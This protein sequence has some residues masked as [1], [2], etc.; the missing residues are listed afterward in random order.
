MQTPEQVRE[1]ILSGLGSTDGFMDMMQLVSLL[2]IPKLREEQE[3]RK[4]DSKTD[5]DNDL[6]LY[7]VE[8]LL[9][10]VTGNR[11]PKPL[12]ETLIRQIFQAYGETALSENDEL[13]S[14]MMKQAGATN[15]ERVLLDAKTFCQALTSDLQDFNVENKDKLS[16]NFDDVMNTDKFHLTL[17]TETAPTVEARSDHTNK[18]GNTTTDSTVGI[19]GVEN[20]DK[21]AADF[22]VP[23]AYTAPHIDNTADTFRSRPLVIFQWTF[24]VASFQT[25]LIRVLNNEMLNIKCNSFEQRATWIKNV[26]AFFCTLGMNVLKWIVIMLAM[27]AIG[28]V[29]FGIGGIGN[30][31]E[32]KN[33]LH[34]LIG[35]LIALLCTL[36]PP[37]LIGRN[38]ED[39]SQKFLE[40]VTLCLGGCAA[41]LMLWHVIALTIPTATRLWQRLQYILVP[42]AIH[43]EY[44]IKQA[45][46]YKINNMV[47]NALEVHRE[48][49][50]E[51]VVPT[52]FGQALLNFAESRPKY[53]RLGGFCWTLKSMWNRSLFRREGLLFSGRLMSTNFIQ[54]VITA[55]ILIAGIIITLRV[56]KSFEAHLAK[57]DAFFDT[58]LAVN[59]DEAL[60]RTI[61]DDASSQFTDFLT[62]VSD[63]TCPDNPEDAPSCNDVDD[64]SQCIPQDSTAFCTLLDYTNSG[65]E[66]NATVQRLLLNASGL[67]T[68]AIADNAAERIAIAVEDAMN[69]IYPTDKYM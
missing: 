5:E 64:I 19:G 52:H 63:P 54:F 30:N 33:P 36:L 62:T 9:H 13:V 45:A 48:K 56:G 44:N 16:T 58:F 38:T 34:P 57:V 20:N 14:R 32:C 66:V 55:F 26:G 68:I 50:Q 11:Q 22:E 39:A 1:Y 47:T 28:L 7:T 10:D 37:F 17:T 6:L 49:K 60:A 40:V 25:Y 31:I 29:Y 15:G 69:M 59:V 51:T 35:L 46:S 21:A 12:T 65:E 43:T 4:Q 67:D 53:E 41:I 8:M 24:F 3:S 42:E 27:S 23:T 18:S 2:L 61:T